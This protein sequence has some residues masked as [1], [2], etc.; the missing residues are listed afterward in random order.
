[1]EY[2]S[3]LL[4][5]LEHSIT[6][7]DI[8]VDTL[9]FLL[10]YTS[11]DQSPIQR[12]ASFDG[13]WLSACSSDEYVKILLSTTFN[14]QVNVYPKVN[15][16]NNAIINLDEVNLKQRL[17]YI[18]QK[19]KEPLFFCFWNKI[20]NAFAHGTINYADNNHYI[21]GQRSKDISS[22]ANFLLQTEE[23]VYDLLINL[24]DK[25]L[26][27][28]MNPTEYKYK[29]L[30][31]CFNFS[32]IDGKHYSRKYNR[33]IIIDDSFEINQNQRVSSFRSLIEQQGS[34][35]PTDIIVN[36]KKANLK[37]ENLIS[38][39]GLTRIISVYD[40]MKQYQL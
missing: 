30:D 34:N 38:E 39:D 33:F 9:K 19:D 32:I 8:S 26:D 3:K 17:F 5:K 29:I 10:W 31:P 37:A 22:D 7:P 36:A 14:V 23:N 27:S 11:T 40:I 6:N 13:S 1:M 25:F 2:I 16:C 35:S 20:R 4:S 18:Y 21:L 12:N 15:D 28:L 24:W